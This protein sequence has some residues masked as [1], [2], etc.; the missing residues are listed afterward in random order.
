[1]PLLTTIITP[2]LLTNHSNYHTITTLR[3]LQ[4]LHHYYYQTTITLLPLPNHYY[5]HSTTI[6]YIDAAELVLINLED[7]G[8]ALLRRVAPRV[9]SL[10]NQVP[11]VV[12]EDLLEG[13]GDGRTYQLGWFGSFGVIR[14]TF[15][16]IYFNT[17]SIRYVEGFVTVLRVDVCISVDSSIKY[18]N[19]DLSLV[20]KMIWRTPWN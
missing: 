14:V 8:T 6:T 20:P 11:V 10:Q 16:L 7:V 4:W 15:R 17:K 5:R 19:P 13:L 18:V 1:M 2:L 3:P 9:V 12:G